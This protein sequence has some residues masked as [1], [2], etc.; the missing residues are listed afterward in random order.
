MDIETHTGRE[1]EIKTTPHSNFSW[2]PTLT[3]GI[4]LVDE[5]YD[6]PHISQKLPGWIRQR[7]SAPSNVSTPCFPSSF[8]LSYTLQLSASGI[9]QLSPSHRHYTGPL[10]PL[11]FHSVVV[12]LSTPT[13]Q[14]LPQSFHP[15]ILKRLSPTRLRLRVLVRSVGA[16]QHLSRECRL[17]EKNWTVLKV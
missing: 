5:R 12:L 10:K 1:R 9:S 17:R 15:L 6:Q 14:T 3:T 8:P 4:L 2:W 16:L 7:L 11:C 13:Q